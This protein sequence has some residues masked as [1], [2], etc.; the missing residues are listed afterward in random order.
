M[1]F[2]PILIS[3]SRRLVSDHAS[4]ALGITSVRMKLPRL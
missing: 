3:Y 4:A 2:A 1:T